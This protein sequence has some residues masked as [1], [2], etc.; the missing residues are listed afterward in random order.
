MYDLL[1]RYN[2][3]IV[4]EKSV[5]INHCLMAVP[6]VKREDLTRVL[7]HPQALAQCDEYLRSLD[8]VREAVD[9]T[10]G[11]AIR[12]RHD[13]QRRSG[14][15]HLRCMHC[16]RC[17]PGSQLQATGKCRLIVCRGSESGGK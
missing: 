2:V 12:F 16:S 14:T 3:H 1:L 5:P 8:V 9:D 17:V 15:L 11:V 13:A 7:S 4:G 6:G 10:A